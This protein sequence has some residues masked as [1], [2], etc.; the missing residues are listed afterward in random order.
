MPLSEDRNGVGRAEGS[1]LVG[2]EGCVVR[3]RDRCAEVRGVT[4]D[5]VELPRLSGGWAAWDS[6]RGV[7]RQRRLGMRAFVADRRAVAEGGVATVRIVPAFDVA[8]QGEPR[9]GV[10]G[11]AVPAVYPSW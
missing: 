1:E 11:E 5:G 10:R 6:S 9:L 4:P 3:D 2:H 7:G 8:K